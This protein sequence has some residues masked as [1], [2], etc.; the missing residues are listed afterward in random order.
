MLPE[1]GR[2]LASSEDVNDSA[3]AARFAQAD[4]GL[5]VAPRQHRLLLGGR[6]RRLRAAPIVARNS[7]RCDSKVFMDGLL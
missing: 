4:D 1:T 5:V 7:I 6:E 2:P 3:H